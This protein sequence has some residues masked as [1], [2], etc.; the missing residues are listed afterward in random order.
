MSPIQACLQGVS[1]VQVLDSAAPDFLLWARLPSRIRSALEGHG[2][3]SVVQLRAASY[4]ELCC[5]LANPALFSWRPYLTELWKIAGLDTFQVYRLALLQPGGLVASLA[6]LLSMLPEQGHSRRSSATPSANI[7]ILQRAHDAGLDPRPYCDAV[8]DARA[9]TAVAPSTT[10]TY[11]SH[12]KQIHRACEVLAACPLPA[13]LDTI[14][15]VTSVVGNPSTLRGW[16]SAWRRLH[17]MARLPWAGDRDPFL[18]AVQLGLRRS[19]GPSQPKL[20]CRRQLLRKILAAAAV[21]K[22]WA[23]GAFACLAYTFGLRVTSELVRQ[24]QSHLFHTTP[25]RITYG[26]IHRKGQ[27]AQQTLTRWCVCSQDRLLCAHDWLLMLCE[28]RPH[29]RLFPEAHSTLMRGVVQLLLGIGVD[30]A[31]KYTSHCFRRGAAADVL[32]AH[33]LASMLRFGQWSSASA[34]EPYAS[35]DEQTAAALGTALLEQSDDES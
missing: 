10:A 28:E 9:G 14:R 8:A 18:V 5:W 33:G 13:G 7:A 30:D 15:R 17:C 1:T 20:R 6:D 22:R 27:A 19:L 12:L 3:H 4:E 29:G 2:V 26:P 25:T 16:L 23:L 35:R 34:A 31:D 24:A 32:E 11:D 21:Q